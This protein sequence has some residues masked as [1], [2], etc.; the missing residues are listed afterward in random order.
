MHAH[1]CVYIRMYTH[2][3]TNVR[4]LL[5][6]SST[7]CDGY[8]KHEQLASIEVTEFYSE[9]GKQIFPYLEI[10]MMNMIIY[11]LCVNI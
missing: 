1:T 3:Y 6:S 4:I 5:V 7:K 10:M 2:M 11:F 9:G 8:G